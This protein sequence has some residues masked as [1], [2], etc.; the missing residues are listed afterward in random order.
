MLYLKIHNQVTLTHEQLLLTYDYHRPCHS[1]HPQRRLRD[2]GNGNCV[3]AQSALAAVERG[4]PHGRRPGAALANKPAHFLST[5]QFGITVISILSGALGEAT[6][7]DEV[8]ESLSS[9]IAWLQP[10]ADRLAFWMPVT[11]IAVFSLILGELVP[12]RL[13]LLNPEGIASVM[14]RPMEIISA[15]AF[16]LVRLMSFVTDLVLWLLGVRASVQ[17]PVTEEEINVLMQQGA[18]AGVFE[19][20]EQAL[21]SRIFQLDNQSI[22]NVMTPRGDIVYFDLNDSFETNRQKLLRSGHSRF[23]IC[24]GGLGEVVGVL[25]AKSVLDA[26]LAFNLLDFASDAV[27][28]LYVPETLTVIELLEAFKKHRQ[29]LALVID[30]H[31]EI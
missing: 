18:E 29:H 30:E 5:V 31:G 3:G 10:Y 21:V 27:K 17:P 19:K 26:S 23:L 7:H 20:H 11:G 13:A 1:D 4:R 24:K 9:R 12:K 14:A 15:I 16:P 25:R 2:V 28:P 22:R 8:A 6:L